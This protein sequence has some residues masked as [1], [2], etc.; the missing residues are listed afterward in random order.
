VSRGALAGAPLRVSLHARRGDRDATWLGH[1]LRHGNWHAA[2]DI[3]NAMRGVDN[4]AASCGV[5][6]RTI[7]VHTEPKN[8]ADLG[9]LAWPTTPNSTFQLFKTNSLPVDFA[10]MLASDVFVGAPSSLSY[11]LNDLRFTLRK[12]QVYDV[13]HK[14]VCA[15]VRLASGTIA[16][17]EMRQNSERC[18][19]I[20]VTERCGTFPRGALC[21]PLQPAQSGLGWLLCVDAASRPN[22]L[23]RHVGIR[24][25]STRGPLGAAAVPGRRERVPRRG[26]L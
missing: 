3:L 24:P 23:P 16:S 12:T 7:S 17:G 25:R 11:A 15:P 6:R 8:N 9:K 2:D 4:L 18:E 21:C 19:T 14:E 13:H 20:H 10:V 26:R 1:N 5:E 22:P